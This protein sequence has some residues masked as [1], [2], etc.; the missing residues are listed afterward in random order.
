VAITREDL[1]SQSVY[2]FVKAGV[3]ARGYDAGK[4]EFRE[5]FPYTV[6]EEQ[7][8]RSLVC[9]GF[10]FDNGGTPGEL[11][12]NLRL[13]EY[14]IELFI[15]GKDQGWG[16]NLASA[17][18]FTLDADGRIPVLNYA[19]LAKPVIDYLVVESVASER[20]VIPDPEPYQENVWVVTAKVTDEYYADAV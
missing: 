13:R 3:V 5:S 12:S 9:V 4:V 6:E 20:Q 16:R 7:L 8:S 2:D 19:D 17:V 15:F 11:G 10:S 1:I 14:T 18:K